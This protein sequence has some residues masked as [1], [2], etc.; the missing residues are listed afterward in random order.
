MTV[1][2]HTYVYSCVCIYMHSIGLKCSRDNEGASLI[3]L[4][5]HQLEMN[6]G[7]GCAIHHYTLKYIHYYTFER[8]KCQRRRKSKNAC[9]TTE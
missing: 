5:V 3:I 8:Y 1:N 4:H 9:I 2:I 7:K 6:N